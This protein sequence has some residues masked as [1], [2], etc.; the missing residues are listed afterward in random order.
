MDLRIAGADHRF[1][2][3]GALNADG[4]VLLA[5]HMTDWAALHFHRTLR[6]TSGQPSIP[7]A[8]R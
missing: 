5:T 6:T 8:S 4:I 7:L 1:P 2:D 3:P